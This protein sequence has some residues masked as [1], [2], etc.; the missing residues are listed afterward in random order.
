MSTL[1]EYLKSERIS[2]SA[3]ASQI[4][5]TQSVVS[6][7]AAG[8]VT[9]SLATALRIEAVTGGKVRPCDLIRD[10]EGDAA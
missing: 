3:F 10:D 6:K 5:I 4:G 1:S 7:L 8:V 9:P 2:Q